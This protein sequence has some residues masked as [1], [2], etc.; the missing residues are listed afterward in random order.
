MGTLSAVGFVFFVYLT[1]TLFVAA[2][3]THKL[4]VNHYQVLQ[5]INIWPPFLPIGILAA[6]FSGE[7]ATMIGSSRVLKALADDEIFGPL[8][9]FVKKGTTRSGNPIAAVIFTFIIAEVK[10]KE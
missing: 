4:L 2:S 10:F 9:S 7:L 6:T 5:E 1:E 8:L 3:C